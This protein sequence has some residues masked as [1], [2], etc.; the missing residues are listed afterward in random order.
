MNRT[1]GLLFVFCCAAMFQSCGEGAF[2]RADIDTPNG[3]EINKNLSFDLPE[4]NSDQSTFYIHLRNDNN[5]PFAN[6]FLVASLR[7]NDSL[8]VRDTLEYAMANPDGSWKGTGFLTVKA[9]KLW[10][11]EQQTP[12]MDGPLTIELAQAN[13]ANGQL[14]AAERLPG[15]VSVGISIE[16]PEN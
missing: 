8:L 5:Y 15:I 16:T 9:N 3:W 11:R 12:L 14:K 2:F 10:W 4:L 6:I 13:R 7:Q 1:V